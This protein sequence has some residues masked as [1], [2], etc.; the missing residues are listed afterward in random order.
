[1]TDTINL[2]ESKTYRLPKGQQLTVACAASS[3]A[4]V[5]WK[6]RSEGGT[7]NASYSLIASESKVL[8]PYVNDEIFKVTCNTGSLTVD[9]AAVDDED[10]T[11]IATLLGTVNQPTT[12][13]IRCNVQR[14][15]FFY[16][17][18]FTL[19]GV[20]IAHTDAAGSGSSASHK[21]FDFVQGA[22]LPVGARTNLTLTSDTTMDVA[23]DMAGVFAL[24]SAAANAGDGA[25]SG[26]EVDFAATKAFTL[27]SNTL[28]VGTN[29][30]LA[31]AAGVDGTSTAA[32]LYLNISGSAATSDA[33]GVITV[34]GTISLLIAMLG[35]D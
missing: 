1:M 23:G 6:N 19:T 29:V 16:R 3:T 14:D 9:Q 35:D 12:G 15:G 34:A 32:D 20:E 4:T 26:T 30:T 22:I 10:Q 2:N 21:L 27:S 25:L 7:D 33:N 5:L 24:G 13:T 17:M 11:N 8:G 31:G 28:A 18:D